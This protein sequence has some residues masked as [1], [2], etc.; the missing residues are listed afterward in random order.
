[1]QTSLLE[2]RLVAR[3]R[4][5]CTRAFAPHAA[6]SDGRPRVLRGEGARAAAAPPQFHDT[7]YNLEP[8]IK[9]SP[10]GLR[11]LQTMI[12]IAAPRASADTW[13][14]L[15][16]TGLITAERGAPA[17]RG[18]SGFIGEL[19]IRLHYLAGR[20]EDRLLFDQQSALAR[21][22]GLA[23][24]PA[25]ARQRTA[26]AALLPRGQAGAPGQRH[27]AAEPARAAVP[28]DRRAPAPLDERLPGRATS[29]STCATT[30]CSSASPAAMLEAFLTLQQHPELK[31]MSARTLRALW[32]N[33]DRIDARVSARSGATARGSCRCFREPRGLTHELRRMN[34]YGILG[35]Y[36]PAFGRIVGQMQHDLFHVYTVDEHILMVIRNLRRFCRAAARA[37]VSAVLA[38]D[39]RFRAP[40]GALPRRRCS[41]TSPRAAAATTPTLGA[42]DARRFCRAH[43]LS[44]EDTELV[45]WLVEHHLMMSAMAQKQ[46]ISDP[47][48]RRRHSPHTVG[49][50]RRLVALY[51]L[52]V[53]D[54]RGTS[55]KVWN[56]WKAKLLED[57]FRA[58]A[59]P[60]RG[61]GAALRRWRTACRTRQRG[62][63]PP[64]APVCDCRTVPKAGCGRS[65][66]ASIS[67]ATRAEE[68]AWHARHAVLPR[69]RRRAG[70]QG[71]AVARRRGP[72]GDD[73]PARPE[74]AVR[75]HLR[76]FRPR[77]PVDSRGQ[78][79]HDAARLR[80]RHV[81]RARSRRSATPRYR[82]T[83]QLIE[84][85]LQRVLSEQAPLRA[86]GAGPRV[87]RQLRHFPLSPEVRIF[88]DDKGTHYILEIVAGD[89][90]GLLARIAYTLAKA[91]STSPAPRSTRWA[92]APRTCS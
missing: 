3:H 40:R 24:T 45:A 72:A 89:R 26:D 37:R 4:A 49:N 47:G 10:G 57:L 81:R 13:R 21:E 75:A 36:L 17:A 28:A 82:D 60:A 5:R 58:H 91:T 62:G 78:D 83:I 1:M 86:A 46:D 35:H 92:S 7:A 16:S 12:W 38:A 19:R 29:C 9:E 42:R 30:I 70:G 77:R 74:G 90:P 22:F 48:R 53:A 87:S 31:G 8:N 71:A 34:Q 55:P 43:G 6:R 65:S 33:R 11:D 15:A 56:A 64:A 68:I 25:R 67:S 54:I 23:D 76:L 80:A 51:L 88:P 2:H 66:T 20:R 50:E 73:L 44:R 27:R 69:R 84:F 41:T 61:G 79:P 32:R 59:R 18:T 39:R 14:E 63:A 85:E 52:T